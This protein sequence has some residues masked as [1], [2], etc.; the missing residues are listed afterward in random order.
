MALWRLIGWAG[1][2]I[3]D[4]AGATDVLLLTSDAGPGVASDVRE[5]VTATGRFHS[6]SVR[7]LDRMPPSEDLLEDYDAVLVWSRGPFADPVA[8]GH[9]LADYVDVGG[10]VVVAA[11]AND[12]AVQGLDGRF[13]AEGYLPLAGGEPRSPAPAQLVP[14][15]P[16]HALL[17]GVDQLDLGTH[18]VGMAGVELP[19]GAVLV[20]STSGGEALVGVQYVGGRPVVGLNL[21]P[22]SNEATP[23]GWDRGTDGATL[24]ANALRYVTD[25]R[26]VRADPAALPSAPA[27]ASTP[28]HVDDGG[29]SHSRAA[30]ALWGLATLALATRRRRATWRTPTPR[31]NGPAGPA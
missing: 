18:G 4:R 12:D 22:P 8:V 9:H 17:R 15:R 31:A 1:V 20:A 28:A 2:L 11:Y 19:S 30:Q 3:P 24:L 25:H 13:V 21:Y 16:E 29:C 27:R 26:A 23:G 10:G 5:V 7:I 14:E 6:V